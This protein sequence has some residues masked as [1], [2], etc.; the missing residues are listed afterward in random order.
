MS[1]S[2]DSAPVLIV[3]D[4]VSKTYGAGAAQVRALDEVDLAIAAG[5]FVAIMGPS[6]STVRD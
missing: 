4:K 1:A 5:E 3:F 6:G 2:A